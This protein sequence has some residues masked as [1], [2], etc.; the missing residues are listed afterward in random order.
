MLGLSLGLGLGLSSNSY[1]IIRNQIYDRFSGT[2]SNLE[3][4]T[5]PVRCLQYDR[6]GRETLVS[7]AMDDTARVWRLR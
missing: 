6:E 4:H 5:K 7:G 1:L 3:G 2:I